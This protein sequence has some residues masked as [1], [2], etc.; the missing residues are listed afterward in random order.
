MQKYQH[1]IS[2]IKDKNIVSAQKNI[3]GRAL[4][5]MVV[6][7]YFVLQINC[8]LR[9]GAKLVHSWLS[10]LGLMLVTFNSPT[11]CNMTCKA[12]SCEHDC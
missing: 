7:Y 1:Q 9:S 5:F 10:A 8:H 11:T 4:I 3:I 12:F 2:A 6:V